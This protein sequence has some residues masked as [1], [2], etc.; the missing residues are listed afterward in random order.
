MIKLRAALHVPPR[1]LAYASGDAGVGERVQGN[2]HL[3]VPWERAQVAGKDPAHEAVMAREA[4]ELAWQVGAC[5]GARVQPPA[6]SRLRARG[7]RPVSSRATAAREHVVTT[8]C[9]RRRRDDRTIFENGG[10]TKDA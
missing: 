7:T 8:M 4:H 9:L 5:G 6:P 3:L 2:E 10:I 1:R